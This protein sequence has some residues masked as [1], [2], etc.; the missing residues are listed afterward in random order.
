MEDLHLHPPL[1]M[2]VRRIHAYTVVSVRSPW[3]DFVAAVPDSTQGLR[4]KKARARRTA[5]IPLI[6]TTQPAVAAHPGTTR[7]AA[8]LHLRSGGI[9]IKAPGVALARQAS[10]RIDQLS[11]AIMTR[12][13]RARGALAQ[14]AATS[15]RWV[16]KM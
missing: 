15:A 1:M 8:A 13:I 2:R 7:T 9:Q 11:T 10:V 16:T 14:S 5:Q 6:P 3:T 12:V 4:V